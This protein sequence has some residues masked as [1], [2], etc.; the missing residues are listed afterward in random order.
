MN[1]IRIKTIIKLKTNYSLITK[2][3]MLRMDS[4]TLRCSCETFANS[5]SFSKGGTISEDGTENM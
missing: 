2:I 5:S 1:K 3:I 4:I